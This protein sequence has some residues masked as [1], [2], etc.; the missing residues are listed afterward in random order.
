MFMNSL[1]ELLDHLA[2]ERGQVCRFA[3]RH[4]SIIR[5]DFLI[6]PFCSSIFQVGL[7]GGVGSHAPP[8]D[9]SRINQRPW[10]MTN[11]GDGF[12]SIKKCAHETQRSLV[13]PQFVG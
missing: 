5:D 12:S 2:I 3:A 8:S 6:H 1:A 9:N 13:A 7:N 10:S 4:K 11:G